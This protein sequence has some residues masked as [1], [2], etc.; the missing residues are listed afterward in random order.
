[1]ETI[2]VYCDESCHLENDGKKNMVLGCVFC[3][4][5]LVKSI[6]K[7][8]KEIKIDHG[9]SPSSEIKWTKVSPCKY[10]LYKDIINYFFDDDSLHFRGL[11][12]PK[13]T[14]DHERF[15]QTHDDWYY[16]MY[17]EMLSFIISP[18]CKYNIFIDIK[19]THSSEK[20]NRLR[21]ILSNDNFDFSH[22]TVIKNMQPVRSHE[23][24]LLQMAD[25][26]TGAISFA[27]EGAGT[28]KTKMELVGIIQS[29]S[30][31]SLMKTTPVREEKINLLKWRPQ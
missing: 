24:Q 11:I 10:E 1:M 31:Y 3:K 17:F 2:N 4:E 22:N 15:N 7:R 13:N 26:L 12:A 16:K 19:D 14:L 6:T 5:D 25:I 20:I 28:S 9:I 21:E 18:S 8:I 23:V 29:K 30:G 27:N